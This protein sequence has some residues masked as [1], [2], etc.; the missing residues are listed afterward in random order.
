[1]NLQD[2]GAIGEFVSSIVIVITLLVLVYEVRSAKRAA[3]VTNAQ[4]RRRARDAVWSMP[5][6]S[7]GLTEIVAKANAHI[8]L[9]IFLE[10]AKDYGPGTA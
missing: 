5:V 8:G 9:R 4:E 2:L 6:D 10:K 1:M 7:P 3:Q